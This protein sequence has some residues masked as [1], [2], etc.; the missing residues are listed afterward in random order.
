[1]LDAVRADAWLHAHGDPSSP[2][3]HAIK[4]QVRNAVFGDADDWKG[5]V[6]GQSLLAIRQALKGPQ[7]LTAAIA[8]AKA[9]ATP[10]VS[11]RCFMRGRQACSNPRCS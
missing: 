1:M 4:A 10:I 3:G 8:I 6:A 7:G 5:M 11:G 9:P 2:E